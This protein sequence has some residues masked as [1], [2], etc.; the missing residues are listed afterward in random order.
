M[1][2]GGNSGIGEAVAHQL[3][4]Q[5]DYHVVIAARNLEASAKV[6]ADLVGAG[7]SATSVQLERTSDESIA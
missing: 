7:H 2:T 4:K 5:P 1:V 3:T 6:V